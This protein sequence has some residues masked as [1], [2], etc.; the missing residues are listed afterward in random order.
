LD[1][2]HGVVVGHDE[3]ELRRAPAAFRTV[4]KISSE[5][6]TFGRLTFVLPSGR[7]LPIEGPEP[8]PDARLIIHDFRFL[9]RVLA[10]GDIGLGEGFMAGE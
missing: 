2:G 8:G 10:A 7:E 3:A 1:E 4:L 9:A 5:N 6:W